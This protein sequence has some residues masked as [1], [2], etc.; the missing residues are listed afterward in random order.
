[1]TL[2]RREIVKNLMVALLFWGGAISL[3]SCAGEK[4][5]PKRPA[6]ELVM[7]ELSEDL[8]VV[9]SDNGRTSYRFN[10]PLVNGY[11]L[12]RE[13]YREFPK[14][15]EIITYTNDSLSTVDATLTANF[16]IYYVDRKIW[17][18][19]GDVVA[20]RGDGRTLYS[21]QLF[22]NSSTKRIYSN[23]ETTIVEEESG[24]TYTGEG[25][26]S[27]EDMNNW[28][29][30][31]M[32]GRMRVNVSNN[33]TQRDS[34]AQDSTK[35]SSVER[36]TPP[37]APSKEEIERRRTRQRDSIAQERSR[38]ERERIRHGSA[39]KPGAHRQEISGKLKEQ[40]LNSSLEAEANK[41]IEEYS[42][43]I[44]AGAKAVEA[45]ADAIKEQVGKVIEEQAQ[46][47]GMDAE[48]VKGQVN[49][50]IERIPAL[51]EDK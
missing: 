8:K 22:W 27:D 20:R 7:T 28:S 24:D 39:P 21:E 37:P 26:E 38:A 2:K 12:A 5:S 14:G 41:I 36:P 6:N 47:T 45:N 10:A 13:P 11:T 30:R 18:T 32:K 29:F 15:I 17:E 23:V 34:T 46:R 44:K 42:D 1:M 48:K 4:Q 49:Q 40:Q 50:A 43:E 9:M 33:E 19:R 16:A 51:L 25:F 35:R 3:Y 31:R